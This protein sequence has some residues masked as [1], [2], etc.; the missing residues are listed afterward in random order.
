MTRGFVTIATG[1]ERYFQIAENLLLSYRKFASVKYP[2]AIICDRK[3]NYTSE[4]DNVIRISVKFCQE[5][6]AANKSSSRIFAYFRTKPF[7]TL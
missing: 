6:F 4:F 7:R 1:A 2:F 5:R 3:N